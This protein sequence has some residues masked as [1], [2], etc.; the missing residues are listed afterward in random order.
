M[1]QLLLGYLQSSPA[2]LRSDPANRLFAGS[3]RFAAK[4]GRAAGPCKLPRIH[5]FFRHFAGSLHFKMS[6]CKIGVFA[7]TLHFVSRPCKILQT[8]SS[9]DASHFVSNSCVENVIDP[10]ITFR[11][12]R[13]FV[14]WSWFVTNCLYLGETICLYL[15]CMRSSLVWGRAKKCGRIGFAGSTRSTYVQF[16]AI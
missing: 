11:R 5:Y 6:P 4:F 3:G 10:A 2:N 7:G 14:F 9:A 13:H 1:T 15:L 12:S 16:R 8:R